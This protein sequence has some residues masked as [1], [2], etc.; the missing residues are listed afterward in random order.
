MKN[1]IK[2]LTIIALFAAGGI[3]TG[4]GSSSDELENTNPQTEQEQ[5]HSEEDGQ[6]AGENGGQP[7]EGEQHADCLLYTSPSPRDA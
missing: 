2:V 4:C 3:L 6:H 1:S 7:E 5:Q